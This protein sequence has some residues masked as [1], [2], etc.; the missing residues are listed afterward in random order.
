MRTSQE[1]QVSLHHGRGIERSMF[2][3]KGRCQA[4]DLR[5]YIAQQI[6]D[7]SELHSSPTARNNSI[8][9][10]WHKDDVR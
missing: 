10:G 5:V 6:L 8:S 9:H 1:E 2:T 3:F 4:R 7:I